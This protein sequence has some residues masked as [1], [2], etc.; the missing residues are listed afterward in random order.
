[1]MTAKDFI[2]KLNDISSRNNRADRLDEI[3]VGIQTT[4]LNVAGGT[5]IS[6]IKNVNFG[7]DWD[8]NKLIITPEKTLREI[9]LDEIAS[10]RDELS[11]IGWTVYKFNN[12][13]REN[14]KLSTRIQELEEKLNGCL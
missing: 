2:S 13:K 4:K 8:N 5:Y 11:K 14:K 6:D 3:R 7:F 10:M 12:L 1:M 9:D